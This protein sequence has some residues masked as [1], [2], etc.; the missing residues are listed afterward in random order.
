M[1]VR[2]LGTVRMGIIITVGLAVLMLL[3]VRGARR[4]AAERAASGMAKSPLYQAAIVLSLGLVALTIYLAG[5]HVHVGVAW[6]VVILVNVIALLLL[7][8]ALKRR[9]PY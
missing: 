7:R 2:F 3:F 9:Y 5:A 6:G 1:P 8:R 4:K